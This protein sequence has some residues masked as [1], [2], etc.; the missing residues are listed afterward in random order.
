MKL[1][2]STDNN[3]RYMAIGTDQSQVKVIR[4]SEGD[5]IRVGLANCG[6][7]TCIQFGPDSHTVLAA[8]E[9]GATVLWCFDRE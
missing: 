7:I 1:F 8:T 3:S 5:T 9:F 4:Y 2:L 6:S